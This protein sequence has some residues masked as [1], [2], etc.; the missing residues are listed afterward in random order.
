MDLLLEHADAIQ[1]EVFCIPSWFWVNKV[2]GSIL[3]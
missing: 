2:L 3:T 1:K